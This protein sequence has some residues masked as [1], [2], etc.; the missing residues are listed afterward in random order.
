MNEPFFLCFAALCFEWG[1]ERAIIERLFFKKI[2]GFNGKLDFGS[3]WKGK[4]TDWGF[5]AF[6]QR[7]RSEL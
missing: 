5:C 4:K 7:L 6:Y 3:S 2:S 1:D